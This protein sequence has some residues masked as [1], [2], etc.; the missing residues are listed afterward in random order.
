MQP[1]FPRDAEHGSV[2]FTQGL[3]KRTVMHRY[4]PLGIVLKGMMNTI[5]DCQKMLRAR[6][7]RYKKRKN[8]YFKV[9]LMCRTKLF[10]DLPIITVTNNTVFRP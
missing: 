1:R 9:T 4:K 6:K 10:G 5:V 2:E 3:W 8:L 7:Q